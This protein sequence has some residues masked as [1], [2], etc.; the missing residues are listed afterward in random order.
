MVWGVSSHLQD[1]CLAGG[2]PSPPC[3]ALGILSRVPPCPMLDSVICVPGTSPRLSARI[4]GACMGEQV[5]A[6]GV[7]FGGQNSVGRIGV[8]QLFGIRWRG[9]LVCLWSKAKNRWKS[10]MRI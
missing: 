4:Q 7:I 5:T 3:P 2:V 1:V 10:T 6:W 8:W 9:L